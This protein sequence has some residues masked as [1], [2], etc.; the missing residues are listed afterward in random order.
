M[1]PALNIGVIID[2]K[3]EF[4]D[5]AALLQVKRDGFPPTLLR[6]PIELFVHLG[7]NL[8]R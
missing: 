3:G 2:S 6:M 8:D 5:T 7:S 1:A 4:C